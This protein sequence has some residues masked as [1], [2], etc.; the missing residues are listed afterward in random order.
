MR[1]AADIHAALLVVCAGIVPAALAGNPA[2]VAKARALE[3]FS[4]VCLDV[5]AAS[6]PRN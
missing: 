1:Q 4:D 5:P 6:A 2:A 3:W